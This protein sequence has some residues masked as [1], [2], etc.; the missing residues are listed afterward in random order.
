[1]NYKPDTSPLVT[2]SQK[3]NPM[4][5]WH[6]RY[7]N[8]SK[9]IRNWQLAFFLIFILFTGSLIATY[10][11]S[12]KAT[13]VPYIIEVEKNGKV[14]SIGKPL[15][16]NYKVTEGQIKYFL[17]QFILNTRTISLDPV[18]YGK[19]YK[20][21]FYFVSKQSKQKLGLLYEEDKVLEKLTAKET[22][23]PEI[24][25]INK[26]AGTPNSYQ[27]R[28]SETYFGKDGGIKG[29]KQY[30][31]IYTL[32]SNPPQTEEALYRNPLGIIIE[33]FSQSIEI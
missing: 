14:N 18:L 11:I 33:D 32:S 26:I 19:K 10:F 23:S 8:L 12:I 15:E 9:G 4:D 5:S 22:V 2:N 30:S 20:E 25:S 17:R 16:Q 21:A 28:W 31:G 1:M 24:I 6:D 29:K 27:I 3:I 13:F 7:L